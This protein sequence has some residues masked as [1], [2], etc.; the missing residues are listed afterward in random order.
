MIEGD[1][2]IYD[3]GEGIYAAM[4]LA[5]ANL[6]PDGHALFINSG[7]ALYP[8]SMSEIKDLSPEKS[9]CYTGFIVTNCDAFHRKWVTKSNGNMI[10][11][12]GAFIFSTNHAAG[13]VFDVKRNT[14]ADT[15]F[16]DTVIDREQVEYRP[17]PITVFKTGGVSTGEN[18]W[19]LRKLS[20]IH[21]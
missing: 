5:L 13:L 6:D 10:P 4:N 16:M 2:L 20:L 1:Q 8:D 18:V 21:I 7:D 12:H 11:M 14:N 19:A 3:Q 17:E 9:Y 15:I